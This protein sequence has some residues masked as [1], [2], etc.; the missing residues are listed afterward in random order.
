MMTTLD[1]PENL[2]VT[3]GDHFGRPKNLLVTIGDHFGWT[4]KFAYDYCHPPVYFKISLSV[5]NCS[6]PA[7]INFWLFCLILKKKYYASL[8]PIAR[9]DWLL[10]ISFLLCYC[11]YKFLVG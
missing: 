3:I 4:R 1:G 8:I 7:V 10:L 5:G 9:K 6:S 2:L 11:I